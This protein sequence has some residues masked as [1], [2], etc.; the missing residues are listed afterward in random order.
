MTT[1]SV[2]AG[3]GIA[4]GGGHE[5]S[6]TGAGGEGRR[7]GDAEAARRLPQPDTDETAEQEREQQRRI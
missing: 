2:I 6:V 1:E 3:V 5:R 4:R 7:G